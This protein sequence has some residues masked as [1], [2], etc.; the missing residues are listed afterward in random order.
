MTLSKMLVM[1]AAIGIGFTAYLSVLAAGGLGDFGASSSIEP[2][3]APTAEPTSP[4]QTSGGLQITAKDTSF[5]KTSLTA[6]AGEV[7]IK[8]DNQDSIPHNL[9]IFNGPKSSDDSAAKTPIKT[10]PAKATLTVQLKPGKYYFQCDVHPDQMHGVLT[11]VADTN[12]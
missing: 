3:P 8:F 5:D 4:A 9:D 7:T 11:V 1:V 10:G 6:K 2:T 12:S